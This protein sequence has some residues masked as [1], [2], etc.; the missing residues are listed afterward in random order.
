MG[1]VHI[2][3]DGAF[4][5]AQVEGPALHCARP[6]EAVGAVSSHTGDLAIHLR[7]IEVYIQASYE[8]MCV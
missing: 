4:R 5:V 3:H 7:F 2:T 8:Y 1:V 6:H